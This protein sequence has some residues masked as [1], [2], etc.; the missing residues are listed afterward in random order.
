M[1]AVPVNEEEEIDDKLIKSHLI[2]LS[3]CYGERIAELFKEDFPIFPTDRTGGV[4][5]QCSP[6]V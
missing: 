3:R 1:D 6:S 2:A 4:R 5:L